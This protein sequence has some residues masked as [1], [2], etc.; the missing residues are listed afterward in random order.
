[1]AVGTKIVVVATWNA[2]APAPVAAVAAAGVARRTLVYN[3]CQPVVQVWSAAHLPR[4]NSRPSLQ[5]AVCNSVH[6]ESA[7][8]SLR[9]TAW[10]NMRRL[11]RKLVRNGS[12]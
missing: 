8:A 1:V 7:A 6:V 5:K 3:S 11:V 9:Q 4:L 10:R 12:R 2:E